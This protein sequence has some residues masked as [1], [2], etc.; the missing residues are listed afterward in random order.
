M[1]TSLDN[2]VGS[3]WF[4]V[5]DQTRAYYQ[6]YI[7]K[8]DQEKTAFVTHWG[9][10]QWI[11]V[12]FGLKNAP[13]C[14]QRFM[15]E[16][17]DGLR[18]ESTMPFLDDVIVFSKR[19]NDHVKHLKTVLQRLIEKG[20]KL[21]ASKCDLFKKEVKYLG[22]VVNKEGYKMDEANIK[23]VKGLKSVKPK[24]VGEV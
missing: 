7:S 18:D 13:P 16:T 8:A 6:G 9:L 20:I 24:K 15:E 5:L 1:Q 23:S 11:R 2:L 19:F 10:Y 17:L 12:P 21:K 3:E 4:S 22:R 14:F